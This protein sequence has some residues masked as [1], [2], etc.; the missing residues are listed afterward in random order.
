MLSLAS[1]Q[2]HAA[3]TSDYH[4]PA[5]QGKVL[6][7]PVPMRSHL[8]PPHDHLVGISSITYRLFIPPIFFI[9]YGD[10]ILPS[11]T[12]SHLLPYPLGQP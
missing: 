8:Q 1:T 5:D 9:K 2:W 4:P 6:E 3:T 12:G 7:N 11:D 10:M